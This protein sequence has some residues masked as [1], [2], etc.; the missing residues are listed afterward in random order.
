MDL[1]IGF[2]T[3]SM[4]LSRLIRWITRSKVS[5]TWML[6]HNEEFDCDMVMEATWEGFRLIPFEVFKRQNVVVQVVEPKY[7]LDAGFKAAGRW[8]GDKYDTKGLFGAIIPIIGKWFRR[9]WHNTWASK[10]ALFCSEAVVD[11]MKASNYPGTE[12]MIAA[13]VGP[14]ALLEFLQ[15]ENK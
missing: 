11:I 2:S 6:Y 12:N 13:D 15:S 10:S 1:K 3:R 4:V 9:K 8:L 7:P 14:E 5:H